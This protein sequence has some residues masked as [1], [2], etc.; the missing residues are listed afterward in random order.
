MP[1]PV[2]VPGLPVPL[3][4]RLRRVPRWMW[5]LIGVCAVPVVTLM[6]VG[7]ARYSTSS[8]SFCLSCHSTGEIPDR[9]VRSLVHP[10]FEKVTC[11]DCHAKPDQ[12]VFE[13]YL[14]GFMAEPERVNQS[15]VRC[16]NDIADKSDQTGFKVNFGNIKVPHKWHLGLGA[17]CV[18][19]HFNVAHDLEEPR[20][21]RPRMETCYQCH[22]RSDTCTKCH[23]SPPPGPLPD[24]TAPAVGVAAEGREVYLR[25]CSACH[26]P[27]GNQIPQ[28][29]LS[30]GALLQ[31]RA[32]PALIHSVAEGKG[33]M[34]AFGKSKGG[35]LTAD[36]LQAAMAYLKAIAGISVQPNG[37]A[38]IYSAKCLVC[39]GEDGNK[40]RGAPLGSKAFIGQLRDAQIF[41]AIANGLGGMPG[42]HRSKG[43]TLDE[44]QIRDLIKYVRSL[45]TK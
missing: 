44:G 3:F 9:G 7:M 30:S 10:S 17:T 23:G 33:V 37:T 42:F 38:A 11:V 34:P 45:A 12:V 28:A 21:N 5:F 29:D 8:S 26:G 19:C 25:L 18:T 35:E 24:F 32:E 31:G 43:G 22:A 15:C 20:T 1:E 14:K 2:E 16:H 40:V 6:A 13:G 39:H 41:E 27:K 36:Q 4:Q